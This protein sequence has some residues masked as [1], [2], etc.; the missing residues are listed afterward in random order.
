MLRRC[1]AWVGEGWHWTERHKSAAIA[2]YAVPG[3]SLAVTASVDRHMISF[4]IHGDLWA[5]PVPEQLFI[6]TKIDLETG[7]CSLGDSVDG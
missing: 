2:M 4:E 7:Q 3:L 1:L 5:N 6:K